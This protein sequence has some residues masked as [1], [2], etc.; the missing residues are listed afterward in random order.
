VNVIGE[1]VTGRDYAL[2]ADIRDAAEGGIGASNTGIGP[3]DFVVDSV[4][5]P[6]NAA[7]RAVK[8]KARES[9]TPEEVAGNP[10]IFGTGA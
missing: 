6:V 9:E 1:A 10:W 4:L 2:G 5:Y 3:L 7:V 8:E